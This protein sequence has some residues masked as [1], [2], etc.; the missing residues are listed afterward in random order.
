MR[1]ANVGCAFAHH[2]AADPDHHRVRSLIIRTPAE[3]ANLESLLSA[4]VDGG[5]PIAL[6]VFPEI[7][8]VDGLVELIHQVADL[9][10]WRAEVRDVD[11]DAYVGVALRW[12]MP[13]GEHE[14]WV[15]GFA[16]FEHMPA[17]RRAPHVCLIFKADSIEQP[18]LK[19]PS[20]GK[21]LRAIHLADLPFSGPVE[22]YG[23]TWRATVKLRETVLG[24]EMVKAARAKVTFTLPAEFREEFFVRGNE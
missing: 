15:L 22:Q 12:A 8:S 13:D 2:I 10:G 23:K 17:T 11:E 4:L 24:G 5:P 21:G 1:S 9:E 14:S 16:P 20:N 19:R 3:P 18:F 6:A 7:R